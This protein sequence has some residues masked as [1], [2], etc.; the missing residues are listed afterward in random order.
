MDSNRRRHAISAA[1]RLS[2][3]GERGPEAVIAARR[4]VDAGN[5]ATAA[6][7]AGAN[8]TQSRFISPARTANA[9][10]AVHRGQTGSLFDRIPPSMHSASRPG[11]NQP[12]VSSCIKLTMRLAHIYDLV[13][14]T[15][16]HP[17]SYPGWSDLI[18]VTLYSQKRGLS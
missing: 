8:V 12:G 13:L 16:R 6:A 18:T 15:A 5:A 11:E 1:A 9:E 10:H 7:S 2:G 4:E 17:G 3:P 14:H